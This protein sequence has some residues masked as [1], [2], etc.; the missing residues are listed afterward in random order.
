MSIFNCKIKILLYLIATFCSLLI[1][2]LFV[3]H[4]V[5]VRN[6]EM[7]TKK[8]TLADIKSVNILS[9]N[10]N[11]RASYEEKL[12]Q[13][14]GEYF[15]GHKIG[16]DIRLLN[17]C[18]GKQELV[19]ENIN[20]GKQYT[21]NDIEMFADYDLFKNGIWKVCAKNNK[22]ECL[23]Y[24]QNINRL[25]RRHV[26]PDNKMF[27]VFGCFFS[28]LRAIKKI[29]QQEKNTYGLVFEDDFAVSDN[30]EIDVRNVFNS[31]PN[32]FDVLKITLSEHDLNK[33]RKK[34]NFFSTIK[35]R[36]C[37]Y[38]KNG[39]GHWMDLSCQADEDTN[40]RLANGTHAYLV[41]QE[42]AEKIISFFKNNVSLGLVDVDLFYYMPKMD[43]NIKVYFYTGKVP[44]GLADYSK[45]SSI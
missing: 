17:V 19:F 4:V 22:T 20:N 31:V 18:N 14:F 30:F 12:K 38:K 7:R 16:N 10:L 42:G 32:D 44:F 34:V 3:S 24:S 45:Q 11:R 9:F 2:F 5:N 8:I 33:N 39:Y 1:I 41:S 40:R 28:H 6:G 13:R 36:L 23:Y 43:K 25:N 35:E 37:S 15:L 21:F 26:Y 27:N 29:S